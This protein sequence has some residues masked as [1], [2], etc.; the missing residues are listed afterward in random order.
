VSAS[1]RQIIAELER[2]EPTI[3]RAYLREVARL[4]ADTQLG[5]IEALI[6]SGQIGAV[7]TALRLD[8]RTMGDVLEAI[9]GVYIGGGNFEVSS[10][11][12]PM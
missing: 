5:Q 12:P 8:E 10:L 1:Q 7:I 9:R 11:R 4:I 6:R 3:A 2:L